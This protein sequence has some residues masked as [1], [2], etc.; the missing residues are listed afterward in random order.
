VGCVVERSGRSGTSQ[1]V[2]EVDGPVRVEIEDLPDPLVEVAVGVRWLVEIHCPSTAPKSARSLAKRLAKAWARAHGGAVFDP[3]EGAV[4]WPASRPRPAPARRDAGPTWLVVDLRWYVPMAR[5]DARAA[6]ALLDSMRRSLPECLPRRFGAFEPLQHVLP[7]D[8]DGDFPE[9][10]Q[11][12]WQVGP[13]E[14]SFYWKARRPADGGRASFSSPRGP[15]RG[16]IGIQ[17]ASVKV[18]F[19]GRVLES[20][21]RWALATASLFGAFARTVPA[22]YACASVV[23]GQRPRDGE[24][25]IE[26]FRGLPR[27]PTWLA[28]FG[29]EYAPLVEGALGSERVEAHDSGLLWSG[30]DVP[31]DTQ[32][33]YG[34]FPTLPEELLLPVGADDPRSPNFGRAAVLPTVCA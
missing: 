31:L 33:L 22:L 20:E 21:P 3:Q 19:E 11:A 24:L 34:V 4:L 2:L 26:Y 13:I 9:F 14:R 25:P 30:G 29:P 15:M 17:C 12:R 7:A 5:A 16:D 8:G 27:I 28:W 10:W 6:T 32:Q 1:P 18:S 23:G